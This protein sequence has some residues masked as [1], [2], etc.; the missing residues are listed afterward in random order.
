MN[1]TRRCVKV[2]IHL[3]VD[4]LPGMDYHCWSTGQASVQKGTNPGYRF[5]GKNA[6]MFNTPDECHAAI[7]ESLWRAGFKVA[8]SARG[9]RGIK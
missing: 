7:L 8:L 2:T 3:W 5:S 4:N 1:A 9:T 6:V